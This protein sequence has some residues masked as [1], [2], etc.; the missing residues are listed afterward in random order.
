MSG[1]VG[2]YERGGA[3]VDRA[4]LQ[5][6]THSLSY[7]GPDARDMWV[8]GAVGFGHTMLW[9]TRELQSQRQPASLDGQFWITADARID[10]R[11]ELIA[12]MARTA[13]DGANLEAWR[14]EA[15]DSELILR[16]YKIWEEECVQYLRGDFSFAIWDAHKKKLFCARDHFG[17]KPF[18]YAEPGELF[19]FSNVLDCLRQHPDVSGDLNDAAIGDFLLFGQNCDEATTTFREIRRLPAAHSMTVSA[20]G[21]R[22]RRY[23]A[24]PTTGRI[25]YARAE[26]FVEHFQILLQAAVADRLR[27]D[28]VGILL[29]GGLDS[30][31][32]A[33]TAREL[34]RSTG[35]TQDL[36]A[37]TVVYESLISDDDGEYARQVAEFLKIPI[38]FI[39][40]DALKPFDRW[41]DP[42]FHWPEPV[43]DP[44]FAGLFDQFGTIAKDCRVAL[45]GEGSDNLMHFQM[46]PYVKSMVHLREWGDL[47]AKTPRYLS[48]RPSVLPGIR[49]RIAER[50]GGD[51]AAPVFPKWLAADFAR[52]LNLEDRARQWSELPEFQPHP[53]LPKAHASLSLPHWATMFEREHAGFT[54][55]PVEV[56]HP[57]VDL[58]IVNFLLAL[59]PFPYFFEKNLLRE[60]TAGRLPESV[61]TRRKAPMAG[62]PLSKHLQRS[63]TKWLDEVD[64]SADMDSYIDRRSMQPFQNETDAEQ[65]HSKIRPLCLNF[66]L[67]SARKVR[68][69]F[70]AEVRNA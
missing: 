34:S 17:V 35:G 58:R 28:R 14:A 18:Y 12:E 61:R 68:Y 64:W 38:Q 59:P 26:D 8:S 11:D 44:F 9:T 70:R 40:M 32:V 57:F 50:F 24:A 1:I 15:G 7:C 52:R 6:F 36:R 47:V 55:M 54:R 46:W 49:R 4:L 39:A 67:Q 16:A 37:Y 69:N 45:S 2:M 51:S 48:I 29:S 5:A 21:L 41:N 63:G 31:T 42:E 10:C 27:V 65:V 20:D 53:V 25:R 66:W 13:G 60:A 30:A 62:D 22:M 56:R 43:D 23:W 19:L 33:A 3:P